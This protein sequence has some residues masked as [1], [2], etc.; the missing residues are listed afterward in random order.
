MMIVVGTQIMINK[1]GL[2]TV[3]ITPA[4]DEPWPEWKPLEYTRLDC[5][6]TLIYQQEFGMVI[7]TIGATLLIRPFIFESERKYDRT[8]S[9]WE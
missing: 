1:Y 4:E 6:P 3:N 5:P 2:L 8:R 9:G 7:A